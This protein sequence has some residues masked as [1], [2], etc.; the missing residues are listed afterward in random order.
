MSFDAR[1]VVA[2]PVHAK[3][4]VA[5]VGVA[6]EE[7]VQCGGITHVVVFHTESLDET[8]HKTDAEKFEEGGCQ[9]AY[10][11][12]GTGVKFGGQEECPEFLVG[13]GPLFFR[14]GFLR[15][16]LFRFFLVL[17]CNRFDS[18]F[19]FCRPFRFFFS[20]LGSVLFFYRCSWRGGRRFNYGILVRVYL[21]CRLFFRHIFA[22]VITRTVAR[23]LA[24]IFTER[25]ENLLV[26]ANARVNLV[27]I[28][29]EIDPEDKREK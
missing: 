28:R 3:I 4:P 22:C 9:V 14:L 6:L 13:K 16:S 15:F 17:F 7:P 1:I 21:C 20:L 29:T 23:F 8:V 18:C 11:P 2:S 25:A 27:K 12:P 5:N 19:R 26:K 24:K 10:G